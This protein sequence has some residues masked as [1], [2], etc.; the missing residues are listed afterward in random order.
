MICGKE[1]GGKSG[2]GDG[3]SRVAAASCANMA[4][5]KKFVLC[6]Q[7]WGGGG[8][9]GDFLPP[10]YYAIH[11]PGMK[12]RRLPY[13]FPLPRHFPH[14]KFRPSRENPTPTATATTTTTASQTRTTSRTWSTAPTGATPSHC[15]STSPSAYSSSSTSSS[16]SSPPRTRSCS[17]STRSRSSTS[18]QSR[19]S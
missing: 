19:P 3:Q 14:F 1:S 5:G 7:H 17:S 9:Q 16:A 13:I 12:G 4:A 6:G 15:R 11:A 2:G 8:D 18:S 10:S